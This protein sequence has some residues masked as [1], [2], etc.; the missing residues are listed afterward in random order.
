MRKQIWKD[1]QGF[2]GIYQ[3]SSLGRVK[4]L[5]HILVV[6]RLGSDVRRF[7]KE[8][9]LTPSMDNEGYLHIRLYRTLDDIRL[10]KVHRLVAQSFLEG[11]SP[12]LTVD[13]INNNKRDNRLSNLR[14]LTR[15]ENCR[16]YRQQ[17]NQFPTYQSSTGQTFKQFRKFCRD[18]E[19]PYSKYWFRKSLLTGQPY[20]ETG[21][22][23]KIID[24]GKKRKRAIKD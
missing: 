1:V 3:V 12:E 18:N 15:S 4:R 19:I 10:F 22:T 20:K 23:F 17:Y 6:K 21:I 7:Y 5:Q 13:H 11:F 8:H 2:E 9:F 16:S 24:T 14:L